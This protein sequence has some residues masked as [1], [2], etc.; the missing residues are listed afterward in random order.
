MYNV[1]VTVSGPK[2]SVQIIQKEIG[3]LGAGVIGNYYC[4]SMTTNCNGFFVP[5]NE[6]NPFLGKKNKLSKVKE[7][8]LEVICK[9]TI[10]KKIVN[11]IRELHPYEEPVINI[12]ALLNENEF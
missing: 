8:K 1:L 10:V 4:C 6:S 9:N 3:K 11:K 7:I 12:I 2:K 5:N